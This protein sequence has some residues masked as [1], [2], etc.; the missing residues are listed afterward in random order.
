MV[1]FRHSIA[2]IDFIGEQKESFTYSIAVNNDHS[3]YRGSFFRG[4]N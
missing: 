1:G 4:S 2:E 3:F